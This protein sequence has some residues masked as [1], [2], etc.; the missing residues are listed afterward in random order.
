[1]VD[2]GG[3]AEHVAGGE[4][5][6][7]QACSVLALVHGGIDS[8]I[9]PRSTTLDPAGAATTIPFVPLTSAPAKIPSASIVIDFVIVTAPNPP[10]SLAG[11]GTGDRHACPRDRSSTPRRWRPSRMGS[12]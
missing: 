5:G 12:P 9:N 1:V 7:K 8:I 3:V 11:L 4:G 2:G 6:G 10:E